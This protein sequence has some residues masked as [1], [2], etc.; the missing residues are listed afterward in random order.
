MASMDAQRPQRYP[1]PK[2]LAASGVVCFWHLTDITS[3]A[4]DVGSLG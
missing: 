3:R 2:F 4:D 1:R